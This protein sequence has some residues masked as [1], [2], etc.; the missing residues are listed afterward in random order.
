MKTIALFGG[1]FDPPHV[2]HMAIVE[3]LT[4]QKRFDKIIV[5]P[6]YLN[7]FKTDFC[8]PS[9]LR[10]SWLKKIFHS[11][12]KVEVCDFEVRQE[13]KVPTIKS[14][15]YLQQKYENIYV[16]IGADNVASLSKWSEYKRLQEMVTFLVA[17]RSGID[18]PK[19]YETLLVNEEISSTELRENIMQSRL[20]Q[21]C[22]VEIETFY[23][24]HNARKN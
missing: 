11:N 20:P 14:V 22:A 4:Q 5:M 21:E 23:K 13:E 10:L 3:A 19:E 7:P 17:T 1:S 6:T 8:A 12:K 16:V 24:E 2:G 15:E 18:V 9:D